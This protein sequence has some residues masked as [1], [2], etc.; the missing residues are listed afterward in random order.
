MAPILSAATKTVGPLLV[1][2]TAVAAYFT[3]PFWPTWFW[4][5]P[6]AMLI[7][8]VALMGNA[9]LLKKTPGKDN[10]KF[11]GYLMGAGTVVAA[12]GWYVIHTQKNSLGKPHFATWHGTIGLVTLLSTFGVMSVGLAA[13]DPDFGWFNKSAP[14]RLAHR[15][16]GKAV[17]VLAY[18]CCV[19]GWNARNPDLPSQALFAVPLLGFGGFLVSNMKF[20]EKPPGK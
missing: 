15:Y 4:Y 12:F 16:G 10:C 7:A 3:T 8:F 14:I 13:L 5:H 6:T 2:F 1:V 20:L 9:T 17:L 11:H 19:L 18:V